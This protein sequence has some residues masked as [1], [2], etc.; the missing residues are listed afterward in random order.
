MGIKRG[1]SFYS[2]QKTYYK[3]EKNLPQLIEITANTVGAR[4][5]ELLAEQMPVGSFPNPSPAAIDQWKEWMDIY[6]TQPVCMDSFIDFMLYK[7]RILTLEEQ[8][9]MMERDIKLCHALGFSVMRVLCVIRRE[10]IR[11]SL[12]IAEYYGV[13][14]GL[15][16]HIPM[17]LKS[18]WITDYLEMVEASGTKFAGLIPDFGIFQYKPPQI[19]LDNARRKGAD[20]KVLEWIV[21]RCMEKQ[22][23][24]QMLEELAA[25]GAKDC[26]MAVA[27]SFV[28]NH[29]NSPQ[30][31]RDV[32][33]YIVHCHG[34]FVD[35]DEQCRETSIN[36]ADPIKVLKEIGYEGYISSEFEG[37]QLYDFG[38]EA[39]EIE[40]VRRHHVMLRQLIGE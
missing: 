25:N 7:N 13:K 39:D 40:Q 8:V 34:K 35:M 18:P 22:P 15:E 19:T 30:W 36:Y 9:Q 1:V 28:R 17:S 26:E 23:V 31:L 16:V 32:G 38:E 27:R 24:D 10:V 21:L 29:Y 12:R 37:Q 3:G 20:E 11:E 14:L 2:Y 5:I 6:Q 4:G 33:K